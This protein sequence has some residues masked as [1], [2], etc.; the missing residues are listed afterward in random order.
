[1]P[2]KNFPAY[3]F[4]GEEDFL[5]EER[6]KKLK[7]SLLN[8]QTKDLNYNVFHGKGRSLNIKEMLDNLNTMPFLSKKRL[9]VLKDADSLS[10][11][12]KKSVLFYLRNPKESSILVLEDPAPN[13]KGSF[14]LEASKLA[15]LVYNRRLTDSA[16]NTYLTKKAGV[17][18]KEIASEAIKALKENLPN[19]LRTFS[20][21]MDNI[22]LYLGKRNIITKEDVEKVIGIS[23][24]HTAFDL[25]DSI[26]RK[27]AEKALRIFLSL[28]RDKKRETE[29]LG[30]LAW[31][32]RMILR[33]KALFNIRNK[34]EMCRDLGLSPRM[35]ERIIKHASRFK[36]DQILT[37][38][39]ELLQSDIDIKTGASPR[40]VIEKLIVKM[41]S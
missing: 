7:S 10:S 35:L 4:L 1:M 26:E 16:I 18:G 14:L 25:I 40:F 21:N 37:L 19:T 39:N 15:H 36:K 22:I 32:T 13:I 11:S 20:S 3:L 2:T 6:L 9:I 28:K 17:S 5:K 41:C 34:M 33:V 27:D 31:N 38:L 24:S 8:N 23:P 30:L 29:L 12:D